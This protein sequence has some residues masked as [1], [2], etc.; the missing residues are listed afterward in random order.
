MI[1]GE[2]LTGK[3]SSYKALSKTL[4]EMNELKDLN[5]SKVDLI[6]NKILILYSIIYTHKQYKGRLSNNKSKV[7]DNESTLWSI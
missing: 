1:I 4:C 3:S 6:F 2:T 5:E 7:A